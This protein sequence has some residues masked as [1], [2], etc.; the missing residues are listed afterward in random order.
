[1]DAQRPDE[2]H[3]DAGFAALWSSDGVTRSLA[4]TATGVPADL[5]FLFSAGQRFGPFLIVRPI[6]KGGMGQVY[7]AE[8]TDSGRRVAV[9]ILSRG[10]GDDEE[11]ERFL[12]EGRLA[13]SLSHPNTVYVF[14]TTEV[15]GFPV[16]AMELAPSGTLKDLVVPGTPMPPA[17]AVDAILEVVAGLEAAALLGILHRDIK[18]SNCFVAADGRVL[19][20]DFGLSIATLA[21]VE[22][23]GEAPGM[24]MGTPGFASPEQLR[25][26]RL[27]VRS[28]I[29][30]VGA[31]IYYLLTGK[32]PFDDPDFKTTMTRVATEAPPALTVSRPD[33]PSRLGSVVAKCLAKKPGDRY[34]S[35]AALRSALEPF[36]SAS[37]TPAPLGRR[38]LAGA[39][40]SYVA[41]LVLVPLNMYVGASGF[42]MTNAR[43]LTLSLLAAV[44]AST[45]YY[46]LLEGRFGCAAGKAMFNLRVV[47]SAEMA[48]G[49]WRAF[50]RATV[51]IL[52]AQ[53]ARLLITWFMLPSITPGSDA[54]SQSVVA[55]FAVGVSLV[56]FAAQFSTVRRR[57]GYAA[58]QDLASGTRVVVRPRSMEARKALVRAARAA[59]AV[60]DGDRV[61]PYLVPRGSFDRAHTIAA[62][63][64]VA[65]FDDRLRRQVW[66]EL[67]PEGTLAVPGWRRD[68]GRATRMRW[69][70]GRRQGADSWDAYEAIDGAPFAEAILRPQ[71]WARVRHWTV[72]LASEIAAGVKEG[73][74]PALATDRIWIDAEDRA[75][76]LDWPPPSVAIAERASAGLRP[77]GADL[78]G[79]QRF[80]YGVAMGALRG[81]D[82][83]VTRQELPEV[84]LPLNARAFLLSLK[85]GGFSTADALATAASDLLRGPAT[86]PRGRRAAQI[87]ACAFIPVIMPIAVLGA[88][89]LQQNSQTGDPK[90]F[91]LAACVQQLRTYEKKGELN[92]TAAQK[93][94][95]RLI[96]VFIAEHLPE[97]V[98]ESATVARSFPILNRTRG[99][100][101]LAERAIANH[102]VRTPQDVKKADEAVEKLVVSNAKGLAALRAPVAQWGLAVYMITWSCIVIA[103]VGIVGALA[104]RSGFA[105]RTTGAALVNRRGERASRVRA[106]WRA[107]AAWLPAAAA[108][109]LVRTGPKIQD[110]TSEAALL[111]TVPLVLLAAGAA[112]AIAHPSRG[113]QDRLAGTTIV[114]Q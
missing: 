103:G 97:E 53:F 7:E 36:R 84:P 5:P 82:A 9:K 114:P 109:L 13:A 48:P 30:S 80:L 14:G 50:V 105:M 47:D 11:R 35:Y 45:A 58:L 44:I 67:L 55:I 101:V 106:V 37:M 77:E 83:D 71:P 91:Q 12:Q 2:T 18:P 65:G 1:M 3:T 51:F 19:V 15:Q 33:L 56:T 34:A 94:N 66:V 108:L 75:R 60:F 79:A 111:Q 42:D 52:P 110:M 46:V 4:A 40:D 16:I 72:D 96:E 69:L 39:V 76:L 6:G 70:S 29:Y 23:S 78:A 90:A 64:L 17:Q 57:N 27:D 31:T 61:G 85:N 87:A 68:L 8:E 73:S 93:E 63:L 41:G 89:H 28:D 95:R 92:L 43:S 86:F 24:I 102:P 113:L 100:H 104:M 32:A 38:L 107:I 88:L 98:Q 49:Y 21:R 62:P 59:D 99:E 22:G 81:Q 10:L 54:A 20:G 74:L 112:W 26:D 25:G